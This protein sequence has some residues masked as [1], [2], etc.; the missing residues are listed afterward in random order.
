M[1]DH[2]K[3]PAGEHPGEI[4]LTGEPVGAYERLG[5]DLATPHRCRPPGWWQRWRDGVKA[6]AIW[7]CSCGAR[8][9]FRPWE[10]Y[11]K[12]VNRPGRPRPH[13]PG[14]PYWWRITETG[15]KPPPARP[16]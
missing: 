7:R 3:V 1:S 5:V 14:F 4:R 12:G 8:Y 13:Q 16:S 2:G 10:P 6:G 15:G 9:E 11:R